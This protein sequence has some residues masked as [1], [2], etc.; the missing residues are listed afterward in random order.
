MT[1]HVTDVDEVPQIFEGTLK[2]E[3]Q[4]STE[5]AE[6]RTDAVV[7]YMVRGTNADSA[8]WLLSGDDMRA[9]TIRNGTLMFRASPDYEN[10]A[11]MGGNNTYMVTVEANV[12]GNNTA[13]RTVTVIV[14]NEIELGTLT[15]TASVDY[16]ENDTVAAGTYTAD[17]PVTP[18]WSLSG[19]DADDFSIGSGMLMFR[20]TPDYENPADMDGNNTYMVTVMAEAGGEMDMMDVTVTVTNVEDMG[21]VTLWASPTEGLKMAPRV[22]D[23]ITGGCDGPGRRRN[24]R[25]L[26]VVQVNGHEQLDGHHGRN[27]RRVHG[28]GRRHG[29]LRAGDSDVH[30][31]GG[32]GHGHGALDADHEGDRRGRDDG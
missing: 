15:G 18:A 14:T 19:D 11:D 8:R 17:G 5:Y 12:V 27:R 28:D 9:F 13:M 10:P 20:A 1:I 16:A 22:G 7:T 6:N 29:L 32:H 21:E 3:G 2:V 25:V 24:R 23:T 30:R 4:S 26:A 31:R